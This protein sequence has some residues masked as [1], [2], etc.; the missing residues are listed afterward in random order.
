[1]AQKMKGILCL[2]FQLVAVSVMGKVIPSSL[3]SDNMVL[4]QLTE[5]Q[6]WGM[7]TPNAKVSVSVSLR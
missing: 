6:L 1:M 5:V 2:L 7:A 3:I 4:Q